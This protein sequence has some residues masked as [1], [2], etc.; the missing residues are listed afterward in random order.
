MISNHL[1]LLLIYT[2]HYSLYF[3]RVS[4]SKL[5]HLIDRLNV[6]Q[7]CVLQPLFMCRLFFHYATA[8]NIFNCA[9]YEGEQWY[10]TV[11]QHYQLR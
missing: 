4:L 5:N 2:F 10:C 6:Y 8:F 9:L 3:A 1:T 7:R 11:A